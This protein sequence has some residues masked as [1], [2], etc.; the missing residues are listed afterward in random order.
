MKKQILFM[1]SAAL[2][3]LGSCTPT[4]QETSLDLQ[5]HDLQGKVKEM[6]IYVSIDCEDL[7]NMQEPTIPG[8]TYTFDEKGNL[9][10]EDEYIFTENDLKRDEKGR[11][12]YKH[13]FDVYGEEEED[14]VEYEI[15]YTYGVGN[16]PIKTINTLSN[17]LSMVSDED[18][19]Y[20]AEGNLVKRDISVMFDGNQELISSTFSNVVYDEKGNWIRRTITSTKVERMLNEDLEPVDSDPV[21]SYSYEARQI[22][23]YE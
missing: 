9:V 11:I 23:Y 3:L 12:I 5:T 10:S 18:A 21:V 19:E 2:L 14:Y 4:E 17:G 22:E 8:S 13:S 20:D 6:A 7:E 1:A 15:E 16:K